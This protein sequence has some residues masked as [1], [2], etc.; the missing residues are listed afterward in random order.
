M[1]PDNEIAK[2]MSIGKTRS[3][4]LI[5]HGITPYLRSLLEAVIKKFDSYVILFDESLNEKT[6]MCKMDVY[7]CYWDS[8]NKQVNIRYWGIEF[9]GHTASKDLATS[10]NK[11][12]E[13]LYQSRFLQ[14]AMAGPNVNWKFDE[15]IVSEREDDLP[16]LINI[17]SCNLYVVNGDFKIEN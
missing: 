11:S 1:L 10:F 9:L 7:I 5:K 16:S 13:S 2:N 6:Q 4:Y 3:V 17:E 12:T 14:I 15:H 8:C